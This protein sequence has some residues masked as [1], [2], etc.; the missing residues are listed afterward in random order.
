MNTSHYPSLELCKK[1][2]E[3]GFPDTEYNYIQDINGDTIVITHPEYDTENFISIC[4]SVM[5]LLGEMPRRI[6]EG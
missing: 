6:I 2:T 4:P 5:E 1:L 3:S